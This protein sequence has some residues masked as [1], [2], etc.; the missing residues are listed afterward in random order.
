ML[1][2]ADKLTIREGNKTTQW[3]LAT[4]ALTVWWGLQTLSWAQDVAFVDKELEPTKFLMSDPRNVASMKFV[5]DLIYTH[6]VAPNAAQAQ[7][8]AQ[9][10]SPFATGRVA[11]VAAGGWNISAFSQLD[12]EW[13]IAPLPMFGYEAGR[14]LLARRLDDPQGHQDPGRRVR[15]RAVERHR[16]SNRRWPRTTTGSRCATRSASRTRWSSGM[17]DGFA[18][19]LTQLDNARIGDIYHANNQQIVEEVFNP[20]FDLLWNNK[21]T[22]D[23]GGEADRREGHR[24]AHDLTPIQRTAGDGN[25][26]RTRWLSGR[27]SGGTSNKARSG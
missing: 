17:P 8:F 14:P 21:I 26:R 9:D 10:V 7:A 19:S 3:G 13:A 22:P 11:M 5:Q 23:A 20:T 24:P 4:G 25:H 1:E 6:K 18:E 12:F 2:A 27:A 16:T 15:V